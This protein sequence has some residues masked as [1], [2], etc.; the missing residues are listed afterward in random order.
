MVQV[1]EK[2]GIIIY[3]TDTVYSMG[4]SIMSK[5]AIERLA[6]IKQIKPKKANFSFVCKDLS[7][8]SSYSKQLAN[9]HY[10]IMK[11]H[12]PGPYTFIV[13]ASNSLPKWL[14]ERKTVGIR[15]PDHEIVR[16]LIDM[17]GHPIVATSIHDA[18]QILE[19]TTDP[20][21]IFDNFKNQVDL[22]IDAGYGGNI[23]STVVDLTNEEIIREGKGEFSF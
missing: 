4:C 6:Q 2:G 20:S 13:E 16:Q 23:P 15:V 21:L 19:Y 22:V 14:K 9:S 3:P 17:L 18:D 7:N 5:K 11:H 1:L 12:L 10:K 8:L